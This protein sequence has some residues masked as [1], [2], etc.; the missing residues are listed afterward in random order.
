MQWG[1]GVLADL[2]RTWLGADAAGG[3]RIAFTLAA[4]AQALG[5]AWFVLGW[6]RY[7]RHTAVAGLAA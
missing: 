6:R 2:S 1:I 3:L 4:C 5:Y 7:A